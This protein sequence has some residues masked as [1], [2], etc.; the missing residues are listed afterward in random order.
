[1]APNGSGSKYNAENIPVKPKS[2]LKIAKG[3]LKEG[4]FTFI[5]GFPGYTT[6]WRTS[7]SVGWNLKNNYPRTVNE[8]QEIIDLL[9][10]TTK[11][12]EEGKI[13]IANLKAGL[14]NTLKNFQGRI[15]GMTKTNFL[16]KKIKFEKKLM[17]HVNNNEKLQ[18]WIQFC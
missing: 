14:A 7:N 4:D 8:F 11:D 2:F 13:K 9:D 17:K 15:E 12:S 1:M 18:I 16:Q 6:R 3:D 5:I 10:E